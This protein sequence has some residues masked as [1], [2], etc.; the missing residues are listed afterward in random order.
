[1]KIMKLQRLSDT[2]DYRLLAVAMYATF[3]YSLPH[4]AYLKAVSLLI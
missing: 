1:M 3:F 4:C 2:R